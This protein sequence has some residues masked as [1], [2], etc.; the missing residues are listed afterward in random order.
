MIAQVRFAPILSIAEPGFIAPFQ[1]AIRSAYPVLRPER[2]RSLAI[3]VHEAAVGPERTTWRF[4]GMDEAWRLSLA[5]EFVALET[6]RYSS[7]EDFL[8]RLREVLEAVGSRVA[9]AVVQRLGL[10]Y[11]D[12]I[13]GGAVND[14]RNLVRQ[15]LLGVMGT[16]LA[17][18][19]QHLVS[20]TLLES[21][22]RAER[23]RMRWGHLPPGGT[24]DPD[25][26]EAIEEP[27]FVLDLDMFSSGERSFCVE[28]LVADARRYA[29]RLYAMFRWAVTEDFLRRYG[30]KP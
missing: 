12:R 19:V 20:Q 5:P 8:R 15:D 30:G 26:I 4:C 2:T 3:E 13:A 17:A 21:P 14:V 28:S 7:R 6:S 29:E 27:S 16:S 18:H 24:V 22:N 11:I 9:P 1:E 25:A 23:L 10:R